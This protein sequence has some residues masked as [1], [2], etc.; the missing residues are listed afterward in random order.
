LP[1]NS[2]AC[3]PNRRGGLAMSPAR[4]LGPRRI[5][6]IV[7]PVLNGRKSSSTPLPPVKVLDQLRERICYLHY[8]IRTE[9]AYVHWVRTFIRFHGLRHPV[10]MGGAEVEAF[11]CWLAHSRGVATSTHK[12]A[13]SALLFF[14]RK[15]LGADLPWITEIGIPCV[16]WRLPVVLS[17]QEVAC[18]LCLLDGKHWLFAQQSSDA[19]TTRLDDR[20]G[21][22]VRLTGIGHTAPVRSSASVSTYWLA[23]LM[24]SGSAFN[25]PSVMVTRAPSPVQYRP[26]MDARSIATRNPPAPPGISQANGRPVR[27][28]ARRTAHC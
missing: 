8:S 23:R 14:Y 26:L 21:A 13:L 22:D 1:L 11:L 24:K 18:I 20:F 16:R 7:H 3:S 9:E 5:Y 12:Q 2:V 28:A 19:G 17:P 10:S 27:K 25:P 6:L 4:G 15:A